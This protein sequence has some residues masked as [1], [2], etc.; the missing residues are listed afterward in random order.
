VQ[1]GWA[2]AAEFDERTVRA[3]PLFAELSEEAID[4]VLGSARRVDVGA[5]ETVVHRWQGTRHFFVIVSG[6]I[7]ITGTDG[8]VLRELG[9]GEFFGELAALDWGAGFGYART[10]DAVARSACR[11]L[12]LAPSSLAAL[13]R[14]APAL[15]QMLRTIARERVRQL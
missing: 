14:R 7:E 6:E 9:P 12:T 10:A 11:L 1:G 13:F 2:D 15:E 5:G 8:E 4:I 3:L